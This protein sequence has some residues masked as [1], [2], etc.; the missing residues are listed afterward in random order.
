MTIL[1]AVGAVG[2]VVAVLA[3]PGLGLVVRNL[4]KFKD[5]KDRE[6]LYQSLKYLYRRNYVKLEHLKDGKIKISLTKQGTTIVKK[7]DIEHMQISK[8]SKWDTRWRVVIYDVPNWKNKNRLAFTDNLKRLGFVMIQKSVWAYPFHC[9]NE[10]MIL[11]KY[12]D[13]EKYVVYLETAMVEDEDFLRQ[14]FPHLH[15]D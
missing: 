9:H 10:I 6:R 3:L 14:R 5:K 2:I 12:Y 4:Q 15:F 7:L 13:I 8:P 1:K 11:R